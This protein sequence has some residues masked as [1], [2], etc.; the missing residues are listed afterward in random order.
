MREA[1]E[2][3]RYPYAVFKGVSS[4]PASRPAGAPLAVTLAGELDFHGLK[5][6]IEVPFSIAMATAVNY[7]GCNA[8]HGE[9]GGGG[10]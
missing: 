8:C 6:R 3:A 2:A 1:L 5:R 4:I 10:D 9:G 7:G